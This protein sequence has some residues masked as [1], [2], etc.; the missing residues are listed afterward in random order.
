VVEVSTMTL[1]AA[2]P[3]TSSAPVV[4]RTRGLG[5]RYG[6]HVAVRSLD[7][8][9]HAGEVFG[10]L[11][12]NGA[13]KTTTI[14]MLLGLSEP[15]SGEAEVLGLD[16]A[17]NP[18]Q[19]KRHVG[20]VPDAVGFYRNLTGRENLRYTCRLNGIDSRDAEV[21]IHDALQRVGLIDAGED[22][23]DTYSR[24]M[25]QRLGLADALVKQ[26]LVLILD[27]PTTSIDPVGV[28][29][30]LDLVRELAHE[31]G[32]AVLLSSHLLHQVQQVCD[33]MAIF[34]AGDVVAMG[35]VAD[36]AA[37][38]ERGV[39]I[40]L[41]VG[42]DGDPAV[43]AEILRASPGVLVVEPDAID[44]RLWRVTAAAGARASIIDSLLRSGHVPWLLRDQ[45]MEL[46]EIYR[47]YFVSGSSGPAVSDGDGQAA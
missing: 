45:G 11:G 39:H 4:I 31:Q 32:V 16:P 14:L 33:R 18:L 34:V 2:T 43:V 29:E 12:P 9:V 28:L 36:L 19:V 24:G 20:Y 30:V 46:D 21:R 44:H 41:E 40:T 22:P 5:K 25:L 7:L 38:Q 13:G 1:A 42:A 10:L 47:R 27:E 6:D 35:T 17:R 26:P 8:E 23:V 37:R 3:V 15:T